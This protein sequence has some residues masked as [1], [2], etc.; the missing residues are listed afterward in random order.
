MDR[1]LREREKK[2]PRA[3]SCCY[4]RFR[5]E[6][7]RGTSKGDKATAEVA[8]PRNSGVMGT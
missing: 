3:E 6:Q 7:R 1:A 4:P 8:E 2:K 5:G